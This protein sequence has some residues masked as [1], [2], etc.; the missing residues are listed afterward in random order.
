MADADTSTTEEQVATLLE[1]PTLPTSIK[2]DGRYLMSLLKSY[3]AQATEQINLAN[4]FTQED[5]DLANEGAVQTPRNF[6]LTFDRFGGTFSWDM[7]KDVT[8][9]AYY[10]L[11]LDTNIGDPNGLLERTIDTS[12]TRMSIERVDHIY[13]YA[14]NQDGEFSTAAELYYNKP[15]PDA[16]TNIAATKSNEGLLITFSEIPTNCIGANIYIDGV[17]YQSLD[18]VFLL[19]DVPSSIET[20]S[21]AFYDPFGEGERGELYFVIPDVTG[22]LVERNGSSLDFYWDALNIYSIRY[23]VKVCTELSWEK[24]VELF[25]TAT[26]DKNRILYP[27]TGEYYLMVKAYDEHGNYSTN[28]AYM[29]MANE[30]EIDRNV[31]LQYDQQSDY[32]GGSKINMYYKPTLEGVTL[33]RE[34]KFGEYIFAVNLPREYKA[35]NWL[36]FNTYAVD[37]NYSLTW[38]EATMTW[39]EATVAWGGK[40]GDLTDTEV[41]TQIAMY[42]GSDLKSVFLAPLNGTLDDENGATITTSQNADTFKNGRWHLGLEV[43]D[44][45]ELEYKTQDVHSVFNLCFTLKGSD[46]PDCII[47]NLANSDTK[48][49][50]L[51]RYCQHTTT[52]TL[53]GSDGITI[54]VK[55]KPR[56]DLEYYTFGISQ[57]NSTRKLFVHTYNNDETKVGTADAL[58]I[59]SFNTL[60]CYPKIVA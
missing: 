27:N 29:L 7:I 12:S 21:I 48:N 9:F 8:N 37:D 31:I 38:D 52:F 30:L 11:R 22:F 3:L 13:L 58:P 25:R 5:I 47:F 34:A 20:I 55:I 35:R 32:Y 26:N 46:M 56:A 1:L 23:V 40:L 19:E 17:K 33:D 49:Y 18:N 59:G 41:R 2:G 10:E 4:G 51:L 16:P 28:A 50:L 36:E 15:Y 24:G 42:S 39:D 53:E 43:T 57:G 54:D 6:R 14:F 45:T 44:L 60:Y